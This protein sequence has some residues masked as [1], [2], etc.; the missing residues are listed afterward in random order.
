MPCPSTQRQPSSSVPCPTP[1]TSLHTDT[2]SHLY[3]L[4]FLYTSTSLIN[5]FTLVSGCFSM[6][7]KWTTY[8]SDIIKFYGLALFPALP[9]FLGHFFMVC[10]VQYIPNFLPWL[11]T[12]RNLCACI[13]RGMLTHVSDT[14][15]CSVF[16]P[17]HLHTLHTD[18]SA[19]KQ[20]CLRNLWTASK[21][22]SLQPGQSQVSHSFP[23]KP[24]FLQS[25]LCTYH[26]PPVQVG[27]T[28]RVWWLSPICLTLSSSSFAEAGLPTYPVGTVVP[29]LQGC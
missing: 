5:H 20:S 15:F 21:Y 18:T 4:T 9:F 10:V 19:P 23:S 14:D 29:P 8:C 28:L 6:D 24:S 26:A 13:C 17:V 1:A 27:W 3:L 25:S 22:P 11:S 7:I 16:S 12:D 2:G